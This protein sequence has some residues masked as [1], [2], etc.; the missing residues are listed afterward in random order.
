LPE[1]TSGTTAFLFTVSLSAVS[2]KPISVNYASADGTATVADN[3]Y[4]ATSGTLS[5]AADQDTQKTVTVLASGDA[6]DEFNETFNV[7][8]SGETNATLAKGTGVATL[9]N[10]DTAPTVTITDV[11]KLE[12]NSG[13]TSFQFTVTLSAVSGKPISMAYATADGTAKLADN[14]Y[15]SKSGTL[16]FA[17]DD[18]NLSQTVTV[19]VAGDTKDEF[20]ETFNVN[21]SGE[22]NATLAKGTGV[23]TLTNDDTPPTVTINDVS[24]TEENAGTTF[25]FTVTLSAVSGK[26]IS[27]AYATADGTATVADNDYAA[28]DDTLAFAPG[29]Q[30]LPV[31]VLVNGDLVPEN[32]ETFNVNLSNADNA[33]LA[34]KSS[35]LGTLTNDDNWPSVLTLTG[36]GVGFVEDQP[37]VVVDAGVTVADRDSPDFAGGALTVTLTAGATA[38]DR[39]AVRHQGA[40][41]G[42]V[43]VSGATVTYGGVAVGTWTGG[44]GATPLVVTFNAGSSPA[45]AQAVARNI[46]FSNVSDTPSEAP[47]T[48]E[49][50]VNDGDTPYPPFN[51][52]SGARTISVTAT[53]DAPVNTVPGAPSVNED[54]TLTCSADNG[55]PIAV[56]DPDIGSSPMQV[57]LTAVNGTLT[58]ATTQNL[59]V[60]GNG[61]GTVILTGTVADVNAALNGLVFTPPADYFGPAGIQIASSDQGASGAG[62]FKTDTDTVAL[63]VESVNDA[64][65]FTKGPD[66][67]V[68]EDSG[69]QTVP[70]WAT[71]RSAGPA[72]ESTQALSFLVTN[73]NNALFSATGQPAIG[74]DGTL[75]F[76]PA[77]LAY[78]TATVTVRIHDDGGTARGGVDTSVAQTFTLD[79]IPINHAPV[80]DPTPATLNM[81]TPT[82]IPLLAHDSAGETPADQLI[83]QVVT[84]PSHGQLGAVVGSHVTYTP[85]PG[86]VGTDSF[87]F[88]VTD[89]GNPPN[90]LL[91]VMASDQP[92]TASLTVG[93]RRVG[94]K[95]TYT[96]QSGD[97][98][99]L[100]LAGPGGVELW[101]PHPGQADLQK[102]VVTGTTEKSTLA[103]TIKGTAATGL[104]TTVGQFD[105]TGSLAGLTGAMVSLTGNL[106][107]TGTLGKLTLDDVGRPAGDSLIQ[108]GGAATPKGGAVLV[109]DHVNDTAV[110]SGMPVASITATEWRET[111]GDVETIQAPWLGAL[112]IKG[113]AAVPGDFGA[114]LTLSGAGLTDPKAKTLGAAAVKGAVTPS[115]WDVTGTAG[116]VAIVGAVGAAGQPWVLKNA[117]T[118][119]SLT[120]GDVAEADVS[121]GVLGA[122]KAVR[123]QAGSIASRMLTSI[124]T[125][126]LAATTL[127]PAIPGDFGAD[128]TLTG[129]GLTAK[130]KTLGGATIKGA[131]APSTWDVTGTTGA[132]AATG[133]VGA[134][135]LPWVLKNSGIVASL[136]L[137]DVIDAEVQGAATLGAVKAVRWQAGSIAANTVASIATVGAA[138]TKTAAAIAGD[139]AADLALA[140]VGVTAKTKTLGSV[141][142]KGNVSGSLWDVKGPVGGIVL[143]GLAGEAAKPWQLTGEIG[144]AHV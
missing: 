55:N 82:D 18:T 3:D 24:L 29:V 113:A 139:F 28:A 57:T 22:T 39:L 53:N 51:T 124:A 74:P 143:A 102:A 37:A 83:Y 44:T 92:A 77:A 98:V 120:L 79:V 91:N 138:A 25:Q 71:D 129:A 72:N 62:G 135:G 65:S 137:G 125:T 11:Q 141:S 134:A 97:V 106:T 42:Q 112:A 78:G 127:K 133:A 81:A 86:F 6:K 8:L 13:T 109:F 54:A 17:A 60:A 68:D 26:P 96:D 47:R 123:W 43:G 94:G 58:L 67:A 64:P 89:N 63:T 19:N 38:D 95:Q 140:G 93:E 7:N 2:G 50:V 88:T 49:F 115:T 36:G 73:D 80:A 4:T 110:L 20:D 119:A 59:A 132:L 118:V 21:L 103:F 56:A 32:D 87:T 5:F 108:I 9:T 100:A 12:G 45:A 31:T 52:N 128:L 33:T 10:D 85:D 116:A 23:A 61:T 84:G 46:L 66:Q 104:L 34:A 69:P 35:G 111:V 75:T 70:G 122:I 16:S 121:A 90:Y 27:V 131:V 142:I 14:D 40:G 41:A 15:A 130:D 117:T 126:G 48:V 99:T 105:V 114:N 107:V 30:F 1:G 144:R 76:T 136:T 101:F